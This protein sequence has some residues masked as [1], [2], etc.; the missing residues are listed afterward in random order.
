MDP[1][2][3]SLQRQGIAV[4]EIS[5][6]EFPSSNNAL[7]KIAQDEAER[8]RFHNSKL[9]PFFAEAPSFNTSNKVTEDSIGPTNVSIGAT[10]AY[11][12][13]SSNPILKERGRESDS[14]YFQARSDSTDS[15]IG[16]IFFKSVRYSEFRKNLQQVDESSAKSQGIPIF[17]VTPGHCS[18]ELKISSNSTSTSTAA[19]QP[20]QS[21]PNLV[22]VSP[23]TDS[24]S[25]RVKLSGR[26][27][28]GVR[29]EKCLGCNP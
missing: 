10:T 25:A 26:I 18:R 24:I 4:V 27:T 2:R 20:L 29:H 6:S 15:S 9:D 22:T 21:V 16:D 11:F 8:L 13:S 3:S 7:D 5:D 12:P 23:V 19:H 28:R 17:P 1:F 14:S